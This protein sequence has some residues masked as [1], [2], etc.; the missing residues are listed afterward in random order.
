[1]STRNVCRNRKEIVLRSVTLHV[2]VCPEPS[3]NLPTFCTVN[4]AR[5]PSVDVDHVAISAILTELSALRRKV[6]AVIQLHNE[7]E[8]LCRSCEYARVQP[9]SEF[10]PLPSTAFMRNPDVAGN[11]NIFA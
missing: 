5:L 3:V 7:V 2:K 4:L 8:Q 6:R 9:D 11:G 1:M 10:L